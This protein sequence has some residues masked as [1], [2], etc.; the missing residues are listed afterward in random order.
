[1]NPHA[2][3]KTT[4]K[5]QVKLT[6]TQIDSIVQQFSITTLACRQT[7]Q[8]VNSRVVQFGF[9][10]EGILQSQ[11]ITN[12]G[13]FKTHFFTRPNEFINDLNGFTRG[14]LSVLNIEACTPCT[15]LT[16]PVDK[17]KILQ[18]E[19]PVLGKYIH[20]LCNVLLLE[21]LEKQRVC[22]YGTAEGRFEAFCQEYPNLEHSVPA[23]SIASFLE[24]DPATL[25]RT[26]KNWLKKAF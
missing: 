6:D 22:R 1:M 2:T 24:M 7:F 8:P 10:T 3:L 11:V 20:W 25:S 14:V 16:L 19:I 18:Q 4:L 17:V 5:Q 26:R 9:V 13:S 23:N 21:I 15:L 12:N